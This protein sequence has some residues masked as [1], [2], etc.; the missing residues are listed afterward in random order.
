MRSLRYLFL[1][2]IVV[3]QSHAQL[4]WADY[5]YPIDKAKRQ[6]IRFGYLTVPETRDSSN[7]RFLKIGFCVLKSSAKNP[8]M[9]PLSIFLAVPEGV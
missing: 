4:E 3:L 5:P 9:M 2:F 6:Q 1:L 8:Q 7:T